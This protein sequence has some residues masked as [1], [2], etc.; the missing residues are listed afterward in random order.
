MLSFLLI[1]PASFAVAIVRHRVLNIDLIIN[2]SIVYAASLGGLVV[3]AALLFGAV[4]A[5]VDAYAHVTSPLLFIVIAVS[6]AM[7][8]QPLKS[9]VQGFVDRRFF[10]L[11]YDFRET[12]R[13][14]FEAIRRSYDVRGLARLVTAEV[15]KILPVDRI[16]FFLHDHAGRR[17]R[18]VAHEEF[19]IL[20]SRG[21][22]FGVEGLTSPLGRPIALEDAVEPGLDT[23]P[24]DAAVFGRW[25]MALAVGCTAED[26]S[27]L[28]FLVLGRKKSGFRFLAEDIDL[29]AGIAAQTGQALERITMQERLILEHAE[30]ERLEKLNRLK[31]YFVSSVTHDLKTPLTSIKMF[32]ELLRTD[33]NLPAK[34]REEFLAIIEGETDRLT[35][36]IN[37]VL[38][39]SMVEKGIKT[40]RPVATELNREVEAVLRSLQYPLT[41]ER[42][43]LERRLSPEPCL[44]HLDRDAFA[45]ALW[46]LVSNAMKYSAEEKRVVVSTFVRGAVAAVRVEDRG[47][48]IPPDQLG[49]IFDQFYR[50]DDGRHREVGGTGLGLAI[51]K[52]IMEG[53][54]GTID[55]ES[56]V[57]EGSAFTLLFPLKEGDETNSG[58]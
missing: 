13:R 38:D 12:Q 52:H 47:A 27:L 20:E 54:G 11:R 9:R 24:A 19:A 53:H 32:A 29:L 58:G 51:V 6:F 10:H 18:I 34:D 14:L 28:G 30:T 16:G 8:F 44:V 41:I 50:C 36:M 55:V 31:S 4:A 40:Y 39:F 21:V 22:P 45:E 37:T 26:G 23:E 2:R 33:A 15:Q 48:G 46:N 3:G 1:L 49:R 5:M 42:F 56:A 7:L 35:R 57:G 25:G 17:L 43:T